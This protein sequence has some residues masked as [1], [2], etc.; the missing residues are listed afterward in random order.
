VESGEK[1]INF[2]YDVKSTNYYIYTDKFDSLQQATTTLE[3]R[4][5]KP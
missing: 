3:S 5:T 1:G 4:G 2:F